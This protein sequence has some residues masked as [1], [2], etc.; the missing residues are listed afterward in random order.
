[1]TAEDAGP[2]IGAARRQLAQ[3]FRAAGLDSPDLDARILI[4]HALG[5]DHAALAA[6]QNR[7]LAENETAAI[8]TLAQRRLGHEPVARIVGAREFWGLRIALNAQTLVPRP[9]SETVV[10]LA[11]SILGERRGERLRIADLDT[12][13]GA[14]L[15]ALLSELP[16]AWCVGT[17]ISV[18]ALN[19]A[20]SNASLLGL[21]A[22][23]GFVACDHGSALAGGFDLVVANPPYIASREIEGLAAEVRAFDPRRALD[24]GEDGLA[25]YRAITGDTGRLL[26]ESGVLVLELGAGQ[27]DSVT[28]LAAQAGLVPGWHR[29]DLAGTPRALAIHR[30][31]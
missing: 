4:G 15:L 28:V 27:L 11:L 10:E 5:L 1:M 30:T 3:R 22:R 8:A 14:L 25:A 19:C 18:A 2:T 29:C 6:R 16:A 31:R 12:G 9:E 17:D 23:A 20:R 21:C 26:A 24:G 7:R 13:S